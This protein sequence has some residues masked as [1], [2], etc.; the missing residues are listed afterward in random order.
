MGGILGIILIVCLGGGGL[1]VLGVLG[2]LV[3]TYNGLVKLNILADEG[4]SGIDVQLKKRYDL[5]PNLVNT[6]KGYAKHEKELL[7]NVTKY[8]NMA[9]NAK[10]PGDQIE[11]DNMLSGTLKSLFAVAE[12]YPDLKADTSFLNLQTNLTAIEGD[13]EKARRYYNGTVREFNSKL[14]VF[15]TNMIAGFLNFKDRIFFEAAEGEKENVKV[16]F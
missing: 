2:W 7:E 11:A 14:K 3:A 10:N 8:R 9:M 6:V 13:L 12:N 16:E 1:L 4:W 5:I 15:P